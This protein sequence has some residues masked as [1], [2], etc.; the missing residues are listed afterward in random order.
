MPTRLRRSAAGVVLPRALSSPTSSVPDV[1]SLRP[2]ISVSSVLFP[3]PL[4][5]TMSVNPRA[6]SVASTFTSTGLPAPAGAYDT[7]LART[8]D[9]LDARVA[10]TRDDV[11]RIPCR[12]SRA[13][14][15]DAGDARAS[16]RDMIRARRDFALR[17]VWRSSRHS[18]SRARERAVADTA[19]SSERRDAYDST[20]A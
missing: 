10:T 11:E 6:G 4:L 19:R 20:R 12:R 8:L 14:E 15:I 13:R 16:T 17:P 18:S 7:P 3:V 5:P 1:G 2:A 9:S